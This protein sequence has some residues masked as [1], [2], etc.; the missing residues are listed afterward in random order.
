[1][2]A[3]LGCALLVGCLAGPRHRRIG[4]APAAS[5]TEARSPSGEAVA[6]TGAST[7]APPAPSAIELIADVAASV[8]A[9]PID[10]EVAAN[11]LPASGAIGAPAT[12][13][14]GVFTSGTGPATVYGALDG[15]SC[16][17]QLKKRGV[18][19]V[20][21]PGGA[22]GVD[23]PIRLAGKLRG[24]D[25]HSMVAAKDRA[26]SPYEIVDCRLALALDDL[27]VMLAAHGV[28]EVIHFSIYRPPGKGADLAKP[29]SEH[30]GAMAI[31]LAIMVKKDGT[32]L[33]VL[34]DWHGGIGQKTCGPGAGP[35]PATKP[36]L[37]IRQILCDAAQ[38]RLFNVILTPN[39]N[40]PHENHFHLEVTKGVKW[41]LL[42]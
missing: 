37:E 18:A 33:S 4:A 1:V 22:R 39:Y 38:K 2:V 23:R 12:S 9:A 41:F 13:A 3:A 34:G 17:T 11:V 31:D 8:S 40:K 6:S 28:V 14:S 21:V 10:L 32:K 7:F 20:H 29:K 36:A 26:T 30:I 42:H 35:T 16:E 15:A 25:F 24:I 27:A 19:Y 5:A